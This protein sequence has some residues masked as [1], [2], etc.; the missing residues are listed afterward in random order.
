M[1]L[2]NVVC[3]D[4]AREQVK[5]FREFVQELQ[6]VLSAVTEGPEVK[7]VGLHCCRQVEQYTDLD[8]R[9]PFESY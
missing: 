8:P 2:R 1:S 9:I 4:D 5:G 3:E 7:D 6:P